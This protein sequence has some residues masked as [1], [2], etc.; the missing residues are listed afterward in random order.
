MTP[1]KLI[2]V[3][4][5]T[6]VVS[7]CGSTHGMRNIGAPFETLPED[8]PPAPVER[9][10]VGGLPDSPI[11]ALP[12]AGVTVS[13]IRVHVPRSLTVSEANRYYPRADIVWRGDVLG[14]RHAQ[15]DDLMTAAFTQGTAGMAGPTPVVLHV[16]VVRFH[17]LTEKARYSIGGVH[18]MEFDLTV[19][20]ASTGE[21]LA[22]TKRVVA[23]LPA[24][25]GKAA[26]AADGRGET[27]KVRV[28][29]F[30]QQ[31]IQQELS[32]FVSG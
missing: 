24:L 7:A 8:K 2:G 13:D 31:V 16:E 18:N 6:A 27:Q 22:P 23:D 10:A 19:R 1:V 15:I 5:L 14:D 28:S 26:I 20:R 25:G 32:R 29:A 21:A 4:C 17:S 3:L 9:A 30:L 12:E 11:R